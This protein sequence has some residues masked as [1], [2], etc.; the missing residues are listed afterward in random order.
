MKRITLAGIADSL[1][2]MRHEV[3]VPAAVA[4]RARHAV[5]RMLAVRP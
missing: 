3:K 1:R 4:E 5:T 2:Y